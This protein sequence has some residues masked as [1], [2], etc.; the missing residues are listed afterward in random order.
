MNSLQDTSEY[1]LSTTAT[2]FLGRKLWK[3]AAFFFNPEVAGGKG[4]SYALG[5]AG[6]SNG[7]TFRIGSPAPAIYVARAFIQQHIALPDSKDEQQDPDQ[8]QLADKVPSSRITI[9]AGK[10]SIA[11]FFDDNAYSHDP[12]SEFMNW[13]L[14]S[15][16][17]WDYPANTRGYTWG[18]AVELIKPTWALRASSVMVP[19]RA[20][21]NVMDVNVDKANSQT[22]EF[23]KK[24]KL[25]GHPGSIRVL[26]FYNNSSA[27]SYREA[28]NAIHNGDTSLVPVFMGKKPGAHYGGVKYGF[29]LS[30]W[31]E[32]SSTIGVFARASWNDGA[33]AT[34][35]FTEIDHS[36][37]AGISITPTFIKR[38]GDEFGLA[39]V[40]N[41]ISQDHYEYLALGGYGFMLG[42]G[43]L[44]NFG[45]ETIVE[46]YYKLKLTS[47]FWLTA[48][49]QF[50][51]NPGYNADRGPVHIFSGRMHVEF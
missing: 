20:N 33:T 16:G 28:I 29:G 37:S 2:F 31:Q 18:L 19:V 25:K 15:N 4:M 45:Y 41:D 44:P 8:N 34:W 49:Y 7:E 26:A 22:I 1:A 35:A 42:D 40:I 17:A 30:A 12:R 10:F 27:P 48:D 6:A 32:L 38:P 51:M 5:L 24:I 9:S 50:V 13:A 43:K 36:A 11:D 23:E 21:G 47:S 3:G 46:T 14:M 39:G